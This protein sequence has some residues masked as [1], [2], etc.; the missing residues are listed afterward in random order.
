MNDVLSESDAQRTRLCAVGELTNCLPGT[1]AK[2]II[3]C[4]LLLLMPNRIPS[5]E[6]EAWI[7]TADDCF[8]VEP[9]LHKT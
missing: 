7:C 8:N 3:K 1:E 2:F 9:Q 4:S 5:A 6:Y